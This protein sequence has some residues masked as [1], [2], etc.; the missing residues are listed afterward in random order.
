VTRTVRR[1]A[2]IATGQVHVRT[3]DGLDDRLPMLM[4]HQSP[5]SSR[6]YEAFIPYLGEYV[7]PFA[8]DTPGHG[9][10]DPAQGE[11]EISDYA[12]ALWA[13]ADDLGIE[14]T[15]LF[16]R[17][18]GSTIA[19]EMVLQQPERVRGPVIL[20]GLP[21]YTVEERTDRLA[22]F[23]PPYP[24]ADDGEH[25]DQLWGRIKDQYPDMP[26]W[27]ATW[28]L[29]DHLLSGPDFA[30]AYRAVFR[31]HMPAKIPELL[32][33]L[34]EE[35]FIFYGDLDRIGWMI[36]RAYQHLP[37]GLVHLMPESTDF[38]AEDDPARLLAFLRPYLQRFL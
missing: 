13:A 37:E 26:A 3:D 30:R 34:P 1:Y 22:N 29:I 12:S 18:T 23:A 19:V 36:E 16:A 27:Q 20:H 17:A 8:L 24:A 31:Y 33:A 21:I 35:P 15:A 32:E 28:Q 10:S 4:L 5:L 14:Q 6:N 11:W 25:L 7:Q 38:V 2:T 9:F